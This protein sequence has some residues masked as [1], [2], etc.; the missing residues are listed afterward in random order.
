MKHK[1]KILKKEKRKKLD[2]QSNFLFLERYFILFFTFFDL[3]FCSDFLFFKGKL[4]KNSGGEGEINYFVFLLFKEREK[5][6]N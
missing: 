1:T 2:L 3:I 5:G 6:K 4:H